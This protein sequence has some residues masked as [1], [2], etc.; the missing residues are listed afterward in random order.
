VRDFLNSYH[1]H[2]K[3]SHSIEIHPKSSRSMEINTE[4]PFL[5]NTDQRGKRTDIT[6]RAN[7]LCTDMV[8]WGDP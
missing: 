4:D 7:P 6:Q 3:L 1:Y 2:Q 8:T 5:G